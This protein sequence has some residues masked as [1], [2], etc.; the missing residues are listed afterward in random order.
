MPDTK[1]HDE[2][3]VWLE[4]LTGTP[5]TL[6]NAAKAKT[7]AET[8]KFKLDAKHEYV[9]VG[10]FIAVSEMEEEE[11]GGEAK[12]TPSSSRSRGSSFAPAL[13]SCV[14]WS[15][16]EGKVKPNGSMFLADVR[17]VIDG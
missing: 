3:T 17:A 15:E 2:S 12:V 7:K 14:P 1:C 13:G 4:G 6:S 8:A 9:A 10:E 11:E 16:I 5:A